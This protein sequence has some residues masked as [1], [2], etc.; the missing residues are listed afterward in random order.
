MFLSFSNFNILHPLRDIKDKDV[1]MIFLK[2]NTAFFSTGIF[3]D[4]DF[5]SFQWAS[6]D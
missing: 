6:S 2:Q 5:F 4:G 3:P 1:M